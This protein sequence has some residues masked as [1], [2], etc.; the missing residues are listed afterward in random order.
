MIPTINS[1]DDIITEIQKLRTTIQQ[2]DDILVDQHIPQD[3]RIRLER[4][5][6]QYENT[7]NALIESK[8]F[9][10]TLES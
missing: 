10:L 4:Q 5:R 8:N 9:L 7:M 1:E 3:Y 2:L 6:N